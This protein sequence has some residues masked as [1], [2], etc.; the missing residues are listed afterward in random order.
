MKYYVRLVRPR[1]ETQLAIVEADTDEAAHALAM[2]QSSKRSADWKLVDFNPADYGC[3]VEDCL[4]EHS[5]EAN[6][7]DFESAGAELSSTKAPDD[8]KYLLLH[9][10]VWSGEGELVLQSWFFEQSNRMTHDLCSDWT[11]DV[12]GLSDGPDDMGSEEDEDTT[13][14]RTRRMLDKVLR[15]RPRNGS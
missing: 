14:E 2:Q 1:F 5:A 11:A 12:R 7:L 3:H 9:A 6:Q 4:S 15:N 8:D 10:D 13:A